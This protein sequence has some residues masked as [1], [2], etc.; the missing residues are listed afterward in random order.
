MAS[1]SDSLK[2]TFIGLLAFTRRPK[3]VNHIP[4]SVHARSWHVSHF[5]FMWFC[6]SNWTGPCAIVCF[7]RQKWINTCVWQPMG[8][9]IVCSHWKLPNPVFALEPPLCLCMFWMLLL[10]HRH[11]ILYTSQQHVQ[12]A[13]PCCHTVHN[14]CAKHHLN[15]LLDP[16]QFLCLLGSCGF[17]TN[18]YRL[19]YSPTALKTWPKKLY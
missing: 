4:A 2:S 3:H 11:L 10:L 19:P 9:S 15:G 13:V 12:C 8:I 6:S 7:G 14:E 1:S 17:K 16:G 18:P 5:S